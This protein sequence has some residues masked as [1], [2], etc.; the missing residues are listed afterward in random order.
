MRKSIHHVVV[1]AA[2]FFLVM[3]TA[4]STGAP[5][6]YPSLLYGPQQLDNSVFMTT[7][8]FN[9][10]GIADI[11]VTDFASPG[12]VWIF[13]GRSS[14]GYATPERYETGPKPFAIAAGDL[15]NDGDID[16]VAGSDDGSTTAQISILI[17]RG[18]GTFEPHQDYDDSVH[19]F[20]I[21]LAIADI[22]GDGNADVVI[23]AEDIVVLPGTGDGKL[24][25]AGEQVLTG[26]LTVH[27]G[28]AIADINSDG[29]PDVVAASG[30]EA[31]IKGAV[32]VF[33]DAED[34]TLPPTP[35]QSITVDGCPFVATGDINGDG[36]PDV[37]VASNS[38]NTVQVLLNVSGTIDNAGTVYDLPADSEPTQP[39]L[40]DLDKDGRLDIVVAQTAGAVTA[41]VLYGNGDG[42]FDSAQPVQVA[43]ATG[44]VVVVDADADGTPDLA[45][46][47][48]SSRSAPLVVARGAGNR[49]FLAHREYATYDADGSGQSPY[50][51]VSADFNNDGAP[52]LAMSNNDAT[53]GVLLNDGQGHF[54][55]LEI[56][57]LPAG[58]NYA[59][60]S[61][62]FNG[63]GNADIA[64]GNGNG[65]LYIRLGNGDGSFTNGVTVELGASNEVEGVSSGDIDND[66][67]ADLAVSVYYANQIRICRGDGAGGFDCN[68]YA[69]LAVGQPSRLTL[70]DLNADGKLDLVAT[71]DVA[72]GDGSDAYVFLGDGKGGFSADSG[73]PLVV[74]GYGFDI[75]VGD[76]DGDQTPDLI[77]GSEGNDISVFT[78]NGDGSFRAGASYA[79]GAAGG[80]I[81]SSPT[82][83][84][85]M[86]VNA[87]GY[88]D[89][90]AANYYDET[91]GIL[92]NNGDGT[93]APA[94]LH[95]SGTQGPDT[96][97][98]LD[99]DGDGLTDLAATNGNGSLVSIWLHDHAPVVQGEALTV[100]QNGSGTGSLTA[101]DLENDRVSFAVAAQ[102][103]HGTVTLDAKTGAYTYLPTRDYSGADSFSAIAND[104]LNNSAAFVVNITVTATPE[105]NDTGD[106]DDAT[107]PGGSSH[108]AAPPAAGGGGG[109]GW[110]GL[111][112]LAPAIRRK[113][114]A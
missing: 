11:A 79:S 75:E 31:G 12:G 93:F 32:D 97:L 78:G 3:G 113:L 112:I 95:G 9:D 94:I 34:G 20:G 99:A 52:D 69:A 47:D 26:S 81:P 64:V 4:R 111:L 41:S 50:D 68:A 6:A 86:D 61:D 98:S 5:A 17:N 33:L 56:E 44:D 76:V 80:S 102:P 106:N 40:A 42:S 53:F 100:A 84:A 74:P 58:Q 19:P 92:R 10:D 28:L 77:F 2:M 39:R 73:M 15:D 23:G 57:T 109:L 37:A 1:A 14:G 108:L 114:Y 16:I 29:R 101:T 107:T 105:S 63:D 35:T 91:L 25:Q 45:A 48:R 30:C 55:D 110:L 67:H 60:D 83:I 103:A 72:E 85:L 22:T 66:G 7:A 96:L 36:R 8:D 51:I 65:D 43:N 21:S 90:A 46:V 89:I 24:D 82:N 71:T 13:K 38:E 18:D 88:P 54:K 70:T 62:D 27:F 104:G 87:D 59:L 49:R